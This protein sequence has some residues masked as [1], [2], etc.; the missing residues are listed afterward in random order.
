MKV[1]EAILKRRSIRR[2]SQQQISEE[3]L[4]RIVKAGMYAPSARDLQPWHFIIIKEKE[5]LKHISEVHPYGKMAEYSQ[6]AILV[7]AD[8]NIEKMVE[9]IALNCAAAT[10]N[11]LLASYEMGIGSVWLGIYPRKERI[12]SM[13]DLF[14]LP[15]NIV[16]ISLVIFGYPAEEKPLPERFKPERIHLETW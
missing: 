3:T 10:Q 2:Y 5:K 1:F 11:M 16:P 12:N 9:Y 15:N 14:N 6:A 4:N 7:C 8:L 13:I